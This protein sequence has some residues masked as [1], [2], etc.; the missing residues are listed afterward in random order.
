MIDVG[1]EGMESNRTC[2]GLVGSIGGCRSRESDDTDFE[3]ESAA[4]RTKHGTDLT[5][6]MALC[7]GDVALFRRLKPAWS[8]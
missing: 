6:S 8:T 2:V 5:S 4:V 3:E 1:V 7:L